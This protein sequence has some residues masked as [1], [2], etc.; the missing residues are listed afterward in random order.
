MGISCHYSSPLGEIIELERKSRC[1]NR[2]IAERDTALEES[3]AAQ[4][5][6]GEMEIEVAMLRRRAGMINVEFN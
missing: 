4:R 3:D 1:S 5:R 6:L 2:T